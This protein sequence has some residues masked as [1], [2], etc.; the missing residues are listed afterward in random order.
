MDRVHQDGGTIAASDIE[1]V[2]HVLGELEVGAGETIGEL[3]ADAQSAVESVIAIDE[4]HGGTET[5]G[6]EAS[7]A[8]AA[9]PEKKGRKTKSAKVAKPK[10]ERELANLADA[11]FELGEGYPVGKS[12]VIALRP[13]Q[14]KIA[15]KF[16]NLFVSIASGKRPSVYTMA[17]FNALATAGTVS[18]TDLVGA[19]KAM[20]VSAGKS[21]GA[22]YNEGTARSQAGQLM[23]LFAVTG[24]ATREKQTLVFNTASPLAVK[25]KA[26]A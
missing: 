10:I 5:S 16:D 1:S 11:T 26:L 8:D 4:A 23:A 7:A 19:L 6:I 17:C 2:E 22:T 24:I 25:L 9:A 21:K 20:T 18:S 12:A 15:D 13:T 3:D 14:K